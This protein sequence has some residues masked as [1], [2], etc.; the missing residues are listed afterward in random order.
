MLKTI[1][2]FDSGFGGELFADYIE[3]KVPVFNVIRVIDWRHSEEII[4]SSHLARK[5]ALEALRPYIGHA[6]IIVFAN[7]LLSMTSLNYF[8]RKFKQQKF[9]GF[10]FKKPPDRQTT[11]ILTTN[12]VAKSTPFRIATFGRKTIFATLDN[13][14]ELIDDGELDPDAIRRDIVGYKTFKPKHIC[15]ACTQF[16]DIE[17][18]LRKI[19]G[20]TIGISNGYKDTL[21]RL[22]RAL[23][24]RGLDGNKKR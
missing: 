4:K 12:A 24:L 2:V 6:D 1:V 8:R 21:N 13:W 9:I 3:E 5:C 19:F 22:C 18:T 17:P 10:D 7:Y 16:I 11:L 15:L 14:P 20:P 23:H